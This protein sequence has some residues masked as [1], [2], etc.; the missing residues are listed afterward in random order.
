MSKKKE[1]KKLIERI[2]AIEAEIKAFKET[3][4]KNVATIS[5]EIEKLMMV[6]KPVAEAPT[7]N[8]RKAAAKKPTEKVAAKPEVKAGPEKKTTP[9]T[10]KP[11]TVKKPV[12]Q[13]KAVP[14]QVE[15]V[16]V[17]EKPAS[18]EAK[19]KAPRTRKPR[20]AAPKTR[21]PRQWKGASFVLYNCDETK[22]SESLYNRND[23]T[24]KD[25]G[26][27]RRALWSKLKTEV[28]EGRIE[29]LGNVPMDNLRLE[30]LDGKPESV[31]KHLKYGLIEKVEAHQ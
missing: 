5:A 10:R 19:A 14:E 8:T 7:K 18:A 24:F 31:S 9:S 22:S 6:S 29:V 3:A 27:G 20:T 16:S 1:L 25:A 2:E 21:A 4:D 13:E 12:V 30:I 11:R 28:T 23:E 26:T 17:E 15:T